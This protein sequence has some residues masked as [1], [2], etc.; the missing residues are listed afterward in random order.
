MAQV[1]LGPVGFSLIALAVLISTA[2]YDKGLILSDPW[3]YYAMAKD[4]V[5]SRGAGRLGPKRETPLWS[6][7]LILSGSVRARGAQ[8]YGVLSHPVGMAV[9]A[10]GNSL[11]GVLKPGHI[12]SVDPQM[13]VPKE[14]LYLRYEDVVVVTEA[15]YENFT[16]FL[17]SKLDVIEEVVRRGDGIVQKF[18]PTPEAAGKANS[19]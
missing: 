4:G 15:G 3:F 7:P 19:R 2:G 9:H 1:V 11:Q 18:P 14:N 17:P 6:V 13:W 16:D 8:L 10:V 5:F 12:F